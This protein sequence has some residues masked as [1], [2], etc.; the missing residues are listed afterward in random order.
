MALVQEGAAKGFN[1]LMEALGI[2]VSGSVTMGSA[3]F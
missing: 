1:F 3:S 2:E